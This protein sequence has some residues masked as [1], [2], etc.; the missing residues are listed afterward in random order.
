MNTTKVYMY[1]D[2]VTGRPNLNNVVRDCPYDKVIFEQS[3]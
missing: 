2:R 3:H 1:N